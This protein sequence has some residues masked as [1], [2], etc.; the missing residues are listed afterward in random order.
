MSGTLLDYA[1][2]SDTR[3]G[4]RTLFQQV[5]GRAPR[6][7]DQVASVTTSSNTQEVYKWLR[8]NPAMK[9]W[10]GDR[11]HNK[12]SP[13][14]YSLKNNDYANG[15][16]VDI[17]DL[18]DDTLG[19]VSL[20]LADVFAQAA[21]HY[22]ELV[23]GALSGGFSDSVV[24]KC[25]DGQYF[26]DSDHSEGESGTQD[27]AVTTVFDSNGAALEA[28]IIAM[29]G[30]KDYDG[31]VIGVRPTHL[32]VPPALEFTARKVLE[33]EYLASGATNVYQ[34]AVKLIVSPRLSTTTEWHLLDLGRA[35]KPIILQIREPLEFTAQDRP[36]DEH[37]Y[38]RR[39]FRY[40]VSGRH[41]VGYSLWQL[42]YGS[43]GGG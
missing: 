30:F 13:E 6:I 17:N 42:A 23:F 31:K 33:A 11:E 39:V 40:G 19:L 34:N 8:G 24:G 21:N 29:A 5:L 43:T 7:Y 4:F 20:A 32:V 15:L 37:A 16:E 25:Y 26:Y 27:N 28:G 41:A 14:T 12:F 38:M 1:N 9:A 18:K 10:L 2:I 36:E 22:D 35:I 3:E